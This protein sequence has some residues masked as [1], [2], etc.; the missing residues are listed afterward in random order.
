MGVAVFLGGTL[1]DAYTVEQDNHYY[2]LA[3]QFPMLLKGDVVVCEDFVGGQRLSP[4]GKI[5]IKLIGMIEYMMR[6]R[7]GHPPVYQQPQARRPFIK[8]GQAKQL[9]RQLP[10]QKKWLQHHIDA[11]AHGL[12]YYQRHPYQ[13]AK[14]AH[15]LCLPQGEETSASR[16]LTEDTL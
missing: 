15:D 10:V 12:C 2:Y 16:T 9:L 11:V 8:D 14:L 6:K 3:Q 5:T 7:T 4:E 1:A 13:P